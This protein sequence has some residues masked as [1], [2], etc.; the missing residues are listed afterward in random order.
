M[1]Q[2]ATAGFERNAKTT[3]SAAFLDA[4]ARAVPGRR[5]AG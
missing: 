2:L 1:R 4:K 5:C 3:P